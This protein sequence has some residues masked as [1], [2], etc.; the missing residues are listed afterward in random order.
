MAGEPGIGE[1]TDDEPGPARQAEQRGPLGGLLESDGREIHSGQ[2]GVRGAGEPEA[3]TA[4]AAAQ[5]DQGLPGSEVQG[6]SHVAEQ[7][8]GDEGE[9]LDPGREFGYG[10]LP[11]SLESG[12]RRDG[13]EYGVESGGRG[14]GLVWWRL[15]A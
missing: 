3:G 2:G 1:V 9:G 12:G 11:G 6:V 4:A 5:V 7:A 14:G 10:E 8:E 13:R 15:G